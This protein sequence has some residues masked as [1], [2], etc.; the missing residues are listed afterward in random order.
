MICVGTDRAQSRKS[1]THDSGIYAYSRLAP[2]S[3]RVFRDGKP[4]QAI[5]S[6]VQRMYT[7]VPHVLDR[8][9]SNH[10]AA[11]ETLM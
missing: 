6:A 3:V 2:V 9:H 10:A 1:D 7:L 11:R 5:W 4:A 8:T